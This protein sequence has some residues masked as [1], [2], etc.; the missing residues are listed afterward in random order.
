MIPHISDAV[1]FFLY[2]TYHNALKVCSFG[3]MAEFPFFSWLNDIPLY[4]YMYMYKY[5]YMCMYM[6]GFFP[7][8]SDGKESAFHAGDLGSIPG[9]GRSPGGG[10]G[11]PLQ[12]SCLENSHGWRRL[13]GYRSRSRKELDMTERIP[14]YRWLAITYSLSILPL[15]DF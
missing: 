12:Y 13:V 5:K 1:F 7:G 15:M 2:F 9:S 4:L 14:L 11:N 6:Q 3:P 8:G 10:Y